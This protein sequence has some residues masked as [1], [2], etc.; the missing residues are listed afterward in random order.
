MGLEV[1][2]YQS[3]EKQCDDDSRG[4]HLEQEFA[5]HAFHEGYGDAGHH[6][7]QDLDRQVAVGRVEVAHAGLFQDQD[8]VLKYGGDP[9]GLGAGQHDASNDERH[10]IFAPQQRIAGLRRG[11]CA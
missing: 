4:P 1:A 2:K 6:A 11:C 7:V 3:S 5:A 9:G 10:D 8:Q